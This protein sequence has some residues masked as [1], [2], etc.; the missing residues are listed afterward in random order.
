M[1]GLELRPKEEFDKAI[2]MVATLYW[3]LKELREAY[4]EQ[5]TGELN[6]ALDLYHELTGEL[7]DKD[8]MIE[9]VLVD[10]DDDGNESSD[11]E[12]DNTNQQNDTVCRWC[13]NRGR[14]KWNDPEVNKEDFCHCGSQDSAGTKCG[15]CG[16]M[17]PGTEKPPNGK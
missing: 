15:W 11:C 8:P 7:L 12:C 1:A 5:D 16:S 13:W 6:E 4:N 9:I 10:D 3:K 17:R 14:R 2:A